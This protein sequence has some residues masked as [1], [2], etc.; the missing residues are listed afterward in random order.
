MFSQHSLEPVAPADP[1]PPSAS[2]AAEAALRE[3]DIEGTAAHIL[4]GS[5]RRVALQ[6]PDMMLVHATAV[7]RALRDALARSSDAKVDLFQLA[8]TA[9][10]GFQVDFVAAQ[11]V[12]ADFIVHYG[13][14]D[15]EAEGPI[16]A[17]F[18]LGKKALDVPAL[19]AACA[20]T[21]AD[22]S[23]VLVVPSLPYA[24]AAE[25][26]AAALSGACPGAVVCFADVER[27]EESGAVGAAGA[28]GAVGAGADVF[29]AA[30]QLGRGR[31]LG[32]RL[33]TALDEAALAGMSLLYIGEEDQT[34]SNLCMLLPNAETHLYVPRTDGGA[35][36]AADSR[37]PIARLAL[38]T[39]ARLMRRYF[40]VQK[41]K[42]AEVVGV[43]IGTLSAA[44]RR[45]MLTAI[46]ALVR[47]AGRKHYVMVMGKLNEAKLANFLEV[48]IYVLLGSAEHSIL[49][50]KTFYRPV[51]TPFELHLAL[52]PGAEW[53]GEYV[54]DYGRMLPRLACDDDD[55][56]GAEAGAARTAGRADA[57]LSEGED[58]APQF[59]LL[60][61]KLVSR[62]R[63]HHAESLGSRAL[64]QSGGA[65]AQRGEYALATDGA[66]FL[67]RRE[68]K[69]L[70]V[71]LGEHAPSIVTEGQTG[72]ASVFQGEGVTQYPDL[73]AASALR[74]AS[75]GA[76]GQPAEPQ[77][78]GGASVAATVKARGAP[79]PGLK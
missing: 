32:R 10:D 67:A 71:R 72:I 20:A 15:L 69:G 55:D 46:K 28:A 11:H 45:P 27:V 47:R 36:A 60:S 76:I 73:L 56:G 64:T 29:D 37:K 68:Y 4:R 7:A 44:Q 57:G 51:V 78:P 5:H 31:L 17:R 6:F 21:F 9:F 13:A 35:D 54:L 43:L 53:T 2:L 39:A 8:D 16:P 75:A 58:E 49:D 48:G 19:A 12:D 24:H 22:G 26:L 33:P 38:K 41:A 79:I 66:E 23:R 52:T 42:E 14:V 62:A 61:G 77:A 34:L 40:L 59:S 63:P 25:A 30:A 3:L 70:E 50:S 74:D 65:L 18:V 1:K